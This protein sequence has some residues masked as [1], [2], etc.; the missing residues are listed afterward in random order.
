MP[1]VTAIKTL[2]AI[3]NGW[4]GT[5]SGL[6]VNPSIAGGIIDKQIVSGD[7]FVIFNDD[8]PTITGLENQDDAIEAFAAASVR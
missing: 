4:S 3:C 8:R 1:N 6:L 7:W 5:E 2:N